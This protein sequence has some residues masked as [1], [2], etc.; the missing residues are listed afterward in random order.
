M[1]HP[2]SSYI[3]KV[4]GSCN[5]ACP[6]CYY[7]GATPRVPGSQLDLN[8]VS[9]LIEEASQRAETVELI[10]HGGEP[11]VAGVDLFRRIIAHQANVSVKVGTRFRNLVQ[12]NGTLLNDEWLQLFLEA[13]FGIGVSL[14]GPAWLHNLT[15]P[16]LS[17]RGSF[18]RAVRGVRLLQESSIPFS[19]L[20]VVGKPSL[21]HAD[22]IFDFFLDSQIKR[23]D[24]LPMVEVK[25]GQEN[26]HAI[27]ENSLERGDFAQ[28]MKR[29]FDL[30]YARDDPSIHVRYLDNVITG[31]LGGRPSTCKFN[32]S[33]S[34]YV[35]VNH[36]GTVLPCDNFTGYGELV[37]GNLHTNSLDELLDGPIRQAFKESVSTT[38]VEC[39][40]CKF[41]SACGGGCN[42]YSYM[43]NQSFQDQNYF[44]GDR[45]EI[46][47]HISRHLEN[48]G[49]SLFTARPR[50]HAPTLIPLGSVA[51]SGPVPPVT[52]DIESPEL[53][54]ASINKAVVTSLLSRI[55]N[56]AVSSDWSDWDR[57]WDR[58]WD[59]N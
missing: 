42:K 17:G 36:D 56:G 14:D 26:R 33:C 7:F 57:S 53:P 34:E 28:F 1:R 39:S 27:A 9:K 11:L 5:L 59:R 29:I 20:S 15:R 30:W 22:E 8:L 12:T 54:S 6:Y 3:V 38:R 31:L 13:D 45:W 19:V 55:D 41:L 37:F 18:E 21:G 23:F 48:T 32:G 16:Y 44:C 50:R 52:Q 24:F 25:G 35:S 2:V 43:W 10:W 47:T 40:T 46:F 49:A 4:T 58:G 51:V